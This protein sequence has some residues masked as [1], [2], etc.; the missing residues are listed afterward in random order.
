M[1]ARE[2]REGGQ[3]Q[4]FSYYGDIGMYVREYIRANRVVI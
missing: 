4:L 3:K 2:I 1:L